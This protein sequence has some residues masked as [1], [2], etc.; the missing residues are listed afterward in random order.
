[1][2]QAKIQPKSD[3]YTGNEGDNND[4]SAREVGKNSLL[5]KTKVGFYIWQHIVDLFPHIIFHTKMQF[6]PRWQSPHSYMSIMNR[7]Q[8][9][10]WGSHNARLVDWY[11]A[12]DGHGGSSEGVLRA[13]KAKARTGDSTS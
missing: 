2:N 6:R 13:T 8:W 5:K 9:S 4:Q 10:S 1:M 11:F 7:Q 3:K 12:G